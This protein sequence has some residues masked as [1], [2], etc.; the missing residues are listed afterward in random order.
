MVK[1]KCESCGAPL[2][3]AECLYCGKINEKLFQ[4]ET[5]QPQ[6]INREK[7]ETTAMPIGSNTYEPNKEQAVVKFL[8]CI[9]LGYFGAHYFYEKKIGL[10]ILYLFTG[11]LFGIGWFI[12]CI[13]LL[14]NMIK[15]LSN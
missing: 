1:M 6:H 2:K 11:G 4:M 3:E 8:L 14:I 7:A 12:D 10:G 15:A 13:R 9:F 5:N